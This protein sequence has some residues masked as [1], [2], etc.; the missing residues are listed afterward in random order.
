[1]FCGDCTKY[2]KIQLNM[3][4]DAP[5]LV[6]ALILNIIIFII[7]PL[8]MTYRRGYFFNVNKHLDN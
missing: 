1:M 8:V 2:I 5:S 7:I 3:D 6:V 4:E